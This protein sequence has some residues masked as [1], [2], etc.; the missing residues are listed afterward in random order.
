MHFS[1]L[2]KKNFCAC[3]PTLDNYWFTNYFVASIES[4]VLCFSNG[5]ARTKMTKSGM[6]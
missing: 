6:A 3:D 2:K 5:I 4:P 1:K